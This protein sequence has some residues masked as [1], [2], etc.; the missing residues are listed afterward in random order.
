MLGFGE[1]GLER[2]KLALRFQH[3]RAIFVVFQPHQH[4]PGFY[5]VSFFDI[6]QSHLA[7]H[8]GSQLDF[9][10][11]DDVACGVED[12]GAASVRQGRSRS[13]ANDLDFGGGVQLGI[14]EAGQPEQRKDRN[15]GDDPAHGPGRRLVRALFRS[16]DPQ[17]FEFRFHLGS[18]LSQRCKNFFSGRHPGRK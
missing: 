3:A 8:F 5:L 14:D 11:R 12:D 7:D 15:A 1:P 4:L 16:I 10:G 13:H 17:L 2:L 6:D 18:D 9:V